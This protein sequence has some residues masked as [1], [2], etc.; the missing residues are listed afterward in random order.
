MPALSQRLARIPIAAT[1]RMSILARQLRAS[2]RDVLS[3]TLGEPDFAAPERAVQAAHAAALAGQNRYP[4]NDGI[5]ALK[6]AVQRKFRRDHALEFDLAEIAVC[7]GA[8]Q[9]ICN[10]MMAS[11]DPG[12][13][14]V[15]P[16]PYFGAYTLM[17][18]LAGGVPVLVDCPEPGGFRLPPG[19]LDAAITPRTRWVMLNFPNNPSGAAIDAAELAALGAVLERHPHVWIL[20]DD[21]YEY[22]LYDGTRSPTLVAVTP[23]L[24]PRTL[25]VSGVSKSYGMAGWRIGFC[26]GPRALVAGIVNM[27]SQ[28]TSGAC[29]IAQAAA[30]A[31]LDG[32]REEMDAP[33]ALY[34]R[35]RDLLLAALLALPGVTCHR[36]EGA[37]YLYPGIAG[38]IGR[39]SPAG[40]LLATDEDV[41]LALLEE[42]GVACVG[43]SAFGKS[44]YLR[45]SYATD[46]AVLA[47]AG[48]RLA[49]FA[50]GLR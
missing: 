3:L 31:A 46:D 48:R 28:M 1:V 12:D 45:F 21:I 14:V 35:R 29:A 43:G 10:A 11:L 18:E 7:N 8:K 42:E 4:P 33:V 13:E 34:R 41:A 16:A 9:V 49:R 5:P 23:A 22:M 30:A 27:Q 36:P 17:V 15:I 44:P 26:A 20:A 40:T 6:Q 37:F 2:G 19:A 39:R 24:R 50:G 25:T 32:P 38:W 47:E